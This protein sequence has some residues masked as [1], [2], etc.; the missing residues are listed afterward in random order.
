MTK[1]NTML[2]KRVNGSEVRRVKKLVCRIL[3]Q[4]VGGILCVFLNLPVEAGEVP[5]NHSTDSGAAVGLVQRI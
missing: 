5:K 2:E 1:E 4:V 3:L